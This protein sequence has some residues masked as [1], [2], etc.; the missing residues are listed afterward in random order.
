MNKPRS[1]TLVAIEVMLASLV[2]ATMMTLVP[3]SYVLAA[4]PAHRGEIDI[5]SVSHGVIIDEDS[6]SAE[7]SSAAEAEVENS[8]SLEV[9]QGESPT[10]DRSHSI[11]F[12]DG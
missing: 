6:E 3:V 1:T 11:T 9:E 10:L 2:A 5:L 12:G 4:D 7:Q 8:L